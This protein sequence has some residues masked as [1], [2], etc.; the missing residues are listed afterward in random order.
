MYITCPSSEHE[1]SGR[2][3]HFNPS[4][5]QNDWSAL[6]SATS[7]P[8]PLS[9]LERR[10]TIVQQSQRITHR[11]NL[12]LDPPLPHWWRTK[13][14]ARSD[15]SGPTRDHVGEKR[16]RGEF[17]VWV[18]LPSRIRSSLFLG[19]RE[20][21]LEVP[22]HLVWAHRLCVVGVVRVGVFGYMGC[23]SLGLV[24]RTEEVLDAHAEP[25]S[26]GTSSVGTGEE[27]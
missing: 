2:R 20:T 10:R 16:E 7:P 26:I 22:P 4:D 11:R 12:H 5:R 3:N 21:H 14:D 27:A 8:L 17:R 9:L 24:R 23:E 18:G 6:S 13:L 19:P 25:G 1:G 15:T